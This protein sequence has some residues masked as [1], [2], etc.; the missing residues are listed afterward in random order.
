MATKGLNRAERRAYRHRRIRRKVAGTAE[1]PRMALSVSNRNISVQ[2]IDDAAA[3]TLAGVSTTGGAEA[4]N[5]AAAAKLGR[6]AAEAA[7][8]RGIRS[9]VVDRGGFRF[10]GRVKALVDAAREAGLVIGVVKA[11]E[12]GL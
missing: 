4:L 5:L 11:A 6:R 9:A 12:E 8:G 3:C 1:R 7:M 10:H 2:F